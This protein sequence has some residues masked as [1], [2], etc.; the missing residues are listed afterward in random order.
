MNLYE[1]TRM[2]LNQ[3]NLKAKKKFGQNFLINSDIINGIIEKSG[4]TKDDVVLE[5][6][7]GLGTLTKE[8]LLEYIK[9]LIIFS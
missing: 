3:Y 5:I 8:L 1:E 2:L 4:I 9:F 6:G 7:P